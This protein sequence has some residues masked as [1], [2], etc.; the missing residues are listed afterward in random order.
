MKQFIFFLGIIFSALILAYLNA[1]HTKAAP[2]SNTIKV[3]ASSSFISKWGPGPVLAELFEKQHGIKVDYL[4]SA[5]IS[6][7]LQKISF[8]GKNSNA[9]AV[10]GLDQ[11]D[12]ARAANKIEWLEINVEKNFE[13]ASEIA[14][15]ADQKKFIAYD[16]APMSFV[17][18]EEMGYTLDSLNALLLPELKGKIALQDPRLSSAGLQFLVWVFESKGLTEGTEFFKKLNQQ[19]HSYSAGW[20][21]AYGLFKNKQAQLVFSYATSPIF[22]AVEEKDAAFISLEFKE[23]HPLQIEFA[24]V[25]VTCQNCDSGTMFVK[26]LQSTEAQKIIMNKNYMLPVVNKVKESTIFDTVKIYKS[27]PFKIYD[28]NQLDDWIRIWSEIRKNDG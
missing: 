25:P 6:M 10:I 13:F 12:L 8:E 16:W 1:E 2:D 22:H 5:D 27:K 23:P 4:E 11:F 21:A 26:Y 14:E 19:V 15:I 20:S 28:K 17:A 3:Y 18:R 7:T 24:G 9:D